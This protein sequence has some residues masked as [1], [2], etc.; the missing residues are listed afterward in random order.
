MIIKENE[1]SWQKETTEQRIVIQ[2]P[3]Y[4]SLAFFSI[5]DLL[6]KL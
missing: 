2:D 3:D 6:D 5:K 1:K 4:I